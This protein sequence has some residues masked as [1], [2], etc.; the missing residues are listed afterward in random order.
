MR[1]VEKPGRIARG[2][3]GGWGENGVVLR[4]ENKSR[5]RRR[6]TRV[7]TITAEQHYANISLSRKH[8]C[9]REVSDMPSGV[10]SPSS[11]AAKDAARAL[12]ASC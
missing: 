12:A 4:A 9:R 11:A 6:K 5:G 2:G 8:T 1:R 10:S 7:Q 3:R